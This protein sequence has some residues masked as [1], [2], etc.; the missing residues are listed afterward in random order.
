M[1]KVDKHSQST[2]GKDDSASKKFMTSLCG[3]IENLEYVPI[4]SSA[5][6][7]ERLF[8][9]EKLVEFIAQR[10][11]TEATGQ[12]PDNGRTK[13]QFNGDGTF[14]CLKSETVGQ[15]GS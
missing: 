12:Y 2:T 11:P 6:Y 1:G 14:Q 5:V 8:N 10:Q 9:R 7:Y 13:T 3:L 4:V 15:I